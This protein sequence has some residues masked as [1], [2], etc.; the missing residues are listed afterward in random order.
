MN[1][2]FAVQNLKMALEKQTFHNIIL[3][4]FAP[5]TPLSIKLQNKGLKENDGK[6]ISQGYIQELPKITTGVQER[7]RLYLFYSF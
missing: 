4:A 3:K 1:N 5:D 6:Y 7:K 2:I